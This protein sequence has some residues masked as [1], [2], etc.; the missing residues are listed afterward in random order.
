MLDSDVYKE[1]FYLDWS[2]ILLLNLDSHEYKLKSHS[3]F[4][5]LK[6]IEPENPDY[7]LLLVMQGKS[8]RPILEKTLAEGEEMYISNAHVVA[9]SDS[10]QVRRSRKTK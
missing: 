6:L 2:Y 9:M 4:R 7:T 3:D 5:H 8:N 1:R 10:V